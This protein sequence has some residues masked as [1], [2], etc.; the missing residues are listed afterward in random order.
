MDAKLS[1]S[2]PHAI[3]DKIGLFD[4]GKIYLNCSACQAPLCIVWQTKPDEKF[5]TK[6]RAKCCHCGDSSFTETIKGF[7]S[8]GHGG[9]GDDEKF[10][11]YTQFEAP[12]APNEK[13]VYIIDTV[14][15]KEWKV[16]K[17]SPKTPK[18]QK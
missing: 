3:P 4:G 8:L 6:V 14:K 15:V 10:E 1:I 17:K 5:T 13:G 12:S 2:T 16:K 7:F 9:V 18:N 11:I